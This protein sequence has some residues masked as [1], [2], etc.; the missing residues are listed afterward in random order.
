MRIKQSI[1]IIAAMTLSYSARAQSLEEG[2]KMYK[3]ERYES[4]K[5]ALAPLAAGNAMANYYLGL[6]ELE[7]GNSTEA[8]AIF[9]KYPDDA[10]NIA[11]LARVAF[12]TRNAAEGDRLARAVADKA[13]KKGW[14]PLKLAADAI[15]Y[16]EGGNKQQA[17]D[18][19][20]EALK[21]NDNSEARI[22][23]GDAYQQIQGGGGEAMNN[24]E[25]VTGKDPKNSLAFSRIGELWYNAKRYDFALEN[26]QK[27]KDADPSNP[28]PYKKLALAYYWTGKY[29][30]AK[31][32]IERYLELSDKSSEDQITYGNI[33][34][35]GKDYPAAIKVMQGLLNQGVAKP[36]M[37]GILGFSQYE[38]KDY[39]GALTN[40][41]NYF[42][43]QDPK[44]I[45]PFDYL[46]YGKIAMANNQTDSAEYYFTK[47]LSLDTAEGKSETYR[48][49]AEG[50]KANKEW[51]KAA[52][53]YNNLISKNPNAPAID[54]FWRGTMY[55]YGKDY[56]AAASAFEGMETKYPDQPSA[57]YWRGRV[58]AATDEEAK[59]GVAAPFY[60]KWLEKVGPN[61]DKKSDLMF[62]Y[63]YLA[64]YYFN[65]GDKAKTKEFMDKIEGIDPNNAFLKQLRDAG[66]GMK[67]KEKN[68]K[69]KAKAK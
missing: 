22:A 55:Y 35:L 65:Q 31:Q 56:P 54:Y 17:I 14:E 3:Y 2:V 44:K 63:Q 45:T 47:A 48:Q 25:K 59:T 11:G 66:N 42:A 61:Y 62:A 1:V 46:Q 32:N 5:K 6:A 51:G 18:W 15:T 40:V 28:L 4:A 12:A 16:T 27:A 29:D 37:Y 19:Y 50:F 52:V 43:Q 24:Y 68:D 21:R 41:R 57:T 39:P 58:A 33:L 64:L 20:K 34:Y 36:G 38:T 53:W 60:I 7:N 23:L 67:V 26:Y 49:I 69:V 13:G 8:K 9:S 30:L 10:A